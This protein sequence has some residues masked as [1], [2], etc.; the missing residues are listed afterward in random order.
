MTYGNNITSKA[1]FHILKT[2]YY[3]FIISTL[4]TVSWVVHYN[5]S[6]RYAIKALIWC[7]R[8]MNLPL[9]YSGL[10]LLDL[11][12]SSIVT[13]MHHICTNNR[14]IGFSPVLHLVQAPF[15][16]VQLVYCS[17]S[18]RTSTFTRPSTYTLSLKI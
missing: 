7:L 9:A 11:I 15:H 12:F 16:I 5:H 3:S 10:K 1:S 2:S 14:K 4:L 13:C 6:L 18:L 8:E 17:M